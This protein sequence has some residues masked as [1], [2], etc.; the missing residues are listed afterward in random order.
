[1]RLYLDA[2]VLF[3]ATHNPR[4]KTALAIELSRQGHLLT[5]RGSSVSMS[6]QMA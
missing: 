1:M 5:V 3:T 2:S 6:S 4:G